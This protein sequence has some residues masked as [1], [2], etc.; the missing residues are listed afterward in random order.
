[1]SEPLKS[2]KVGSANRADRIID[3]EVEQVHPVARSGF[4]RRMGWLLLAVAV[5]VA[6]AA[7]YHFYDQMLLQRGAP[8]AAPVATGAGGNAPVAGTATPPAQPDPAAARRMD[9]LERRITA[10]TAAMER[11]RDVSPAAAGDT[12]VLSQR[13]D[14]L[15]ARLTATLSDVQQKEAQRLDALARDL[16]RAGER[17]EL[18]EAKLAEL[19]AARHA[20]LRLPVAVLASWMNVHGRAQ[21]GEAF[22]AEAD[23]LSAL[24]AREPVK[25]LTESFAAVRSMAAQG[26]PTAAIL[27]ASFPEVSEAEQ[28]S[29]AEAPD[30]ALP[31]WQRMFQKLAG[32]I[33]IRRTRGGPADDAQ[34]DAA[35]LLERAE[36]ALRR[37]DLADALAATESLAGS[38]ELKTW[39]EAARRRLQLDAALSGFSAQLRRHF[40]TEG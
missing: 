17:L 39:R 27:A 31:W 25:D 19:T 20:S 7:G 21:A 32:L 28:R 4:W 6:L 16:A 8:A 1:M 33:T 40:G 11:L 24:L 15:E 26:T 14:A 30:P 3:A 22:A 23:A 37:G 12:A 5:S 36:A 35:S 18:L 38:D 13:L 29:A 9:E 34:G 10:M 2:E